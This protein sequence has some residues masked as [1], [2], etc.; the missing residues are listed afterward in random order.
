M[1]LRSAETLRALTKQEGLSYRDIAD[2]ADCSYSFIGHLVAGRRNCSPEL[3]DRIAEVV[4]VPTGVLFAADAPSGG[5][6]NAL[7][8]RTAA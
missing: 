6:R 3:A 7:T 8:S 1:H 4:G 2:G 5:G